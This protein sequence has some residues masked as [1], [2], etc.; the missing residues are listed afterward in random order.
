MNKPVKKPNFIIRKDPSAR[1]LDSFCFRWDPHLV[2]HGVFPIISSSDILWMTHTT[3]ITR[4]VLQSEQHRFAGPLAESTL[5][6]YI[7][8]VSCSPSIQCY[9]KNKT[10]RW[11]TIWFFKNLS[12]C[13]SD[14]SPADISA[15]YPQLFTWANKYFSMLTGIVTYLHYILITVSNVDTI[16]DLLSSFMLVI[17]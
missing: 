5:K 2:S 4:A 7:Q 8:L 14:H 11:F 3:S 1:V 17:F 10:K 15:K 6:I 13:Q 9:I 12:C 16:W